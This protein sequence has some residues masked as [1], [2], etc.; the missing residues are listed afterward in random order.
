[1]KPAAYLVHVG[2]GTPSYR[3][4]QCSTRAEARQCAAYARA[5][6]CTVRIEAKGF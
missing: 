1:M 2:E 3:V 5:K 4:I 6:L